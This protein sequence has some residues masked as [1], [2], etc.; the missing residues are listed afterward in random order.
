[1]DYFTHDELLFEIPVYRHSPDQ[2]RNFLEQLTA[3]HLQRAETHA[4]E[5]PWDRET[6]DER[7]ERTEARVRRRYGRPFLYNEMIG[8]IRLYQDGSSIKGELWRQ[9][10]GRLRRNFNHYTYEPWARVVEWHPAFPPETSIDVYEEL[11]EQLTE[12]P[13]GDILKGRYLDLHAFRRVG[14]HIDWLT[15]L[16]WRQL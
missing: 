1:M 4:H 5:P 8:V 11:L 10:H 9:P 16:D 14:P 7:R 6:P 3:T 2:H 13:T 15:V 12:L